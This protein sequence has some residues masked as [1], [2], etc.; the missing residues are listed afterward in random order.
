MANHPAPPLSVNE[1]DHE[2][3]RALIRAR[4]TEQRLVQR[5]RIVLRAAEGQPNRR[6]ATALGVAPMTVLLWRARYPRA[7]PLGSPM[8]P[9]RDV[10]RGTDATSAIRS[11]P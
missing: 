8:R 6:I 3:L 5:A 4:T 1:S 11:S 2:I 9:V 7:V 10:R